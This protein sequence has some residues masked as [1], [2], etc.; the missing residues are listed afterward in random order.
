MLRAADPAPGTLLTGVNVIDKAGG[1]VNG[2]NGTGYFVQSGSL[3]ID[4]AT[5]Q[6]F[7]S[8]GGD[9]SGGGAGL[10]GAVFVN[11]GATV[12]LNN[13]NLVSNYASGG[14]GGVGSVGGSLNGLFQVGSSGSTG[15]A[16]ADADVGGAYVNGGNGLNGYNGYAGGNASSGLGGTG[17]RGGNGSDGA[18][19]TADTVKAALDVGFDA[20]KLGQDT[21]EFGI[22]TGIA[23]TMTA[24][25]TAAAAGVNV[26]GP[27]TTHLAPIF[28]ALAGEFTAKA[29]TS[30]A[31]AG[32]DVA[33]AAFDAAYLTAITVTNIAVGSAGNGGAGGAGGR[34]GQGAFGFGG[35]DGGV[36]GNGGDALFL[37]AGAGGP[38]GTGGDGGVGGFGAGGGLG[39]DGGGAGESGFGVSNADAT[40]TGGAG[41]V[42]GFGGGA[43]ASGDGIAALAAGGNGGSAFG[44]AI[45]V[46]AGGTLIIQG[47]ALFE[48]N[49][50]N[51]GAG[52]TASNT[53]AA[54]VSGIVVG[55]DLYM[56]KGSTV[57]LD[58]GEGHV[59]Q[60][61]GNPY[62]TSISDDSASSMIP[63]GGIS[64]IPSGQGA[65]LTVKSGLVIFNGSN[66]YSGQT[67]LEGGVLQALD[68]D[69]IYYDSNINFAGGVLQSNGD[70]T[71]AVG[72]A[73]SKV[74]WTGDGGFAAAG[75]DLS[76]RL[77]NGATLTWDSGSFVPT[78][79]KLIFGS[80]SADSSVT[81]FNNINLNGGNRTIV[82]K[83]NDLIP[84]NDTDEEVPANID[85]ATIRGVLSNGSLTVG[86][87][88]Y[89]GVLNLGAANTYAGGTTVNGGTLALVEIHNP[90][91]GHLISTGS[92]NA[93]GAVTVDAAGTFDI[94]QT[95]DQSIGALAGAGTVN[96]GANVLTL[97]QATD[98]T[99]SGAL[100]DGGIG[101]GEGAGVTKKGIGTLTL[102]G[103]N[104]YT[105][106]TQIDAGRITLTGT[107][108]SRTVNVASGATLDDVNGGLHDETA[109]TNAGT[110]NLSADD[111]VASF[112]SNAG[113]LNGAGKSLT[114][115]TYDLNTGTTINASL[116]AGEVT[117]NGTVALNGTSAAATFTIETGTTTLGSAER[118]LDT[119]DLTLSDGATLVLGGNEKIGTL[120]GA[121]SLNNNGGRL[122]VD[123]GS[124]SGVI[125]G[126]GGLTKVSSGK[127]T[128]TGASTYTGSTLI[129][130]GTVELSGSGSLVSDNVQIASGA[131]LDDLN[132][133]LSASAAVTNDGTLNIAAADDTITTL[134]NTG[135]VNGT[136][137]LTATTYNL[138]DSSV[139]NANLGT[140]TVNASGAVALNGTSNAETVNVQTGTTTLGSAERLRDDTD[141]TVSDGATLVLGG[142]EKIGTF[143][144]AGT[145]ALG[146]SQLTV[147]DG[148]YSGVVTGTGGIDKVSSGLLTL[149]GNST[150]TG[151]TNVDAGTLTLTG[152]LESLTVTVDA[153]TTINNVNGGLAE[154]ATLNND[155]TTVLG[156][157][158]TIT[159]FNS[160]DTLDGIGKTLTAETY[161]LNDGSVIN[162]NLGTGTVNANGEVALNGTSSAETV[163][164]QTGTTTL[165]SA[166]R[167]LD[168]TDLTISE[169]ATLILGGDEKIG[170]LDG[171]GVLQNAGGRL[172]VDDGDFSGVISGS[173]GLTKV[174][175]GTLTLSGEN[176][177]TG[178]TLITAGAVTL[179]GS[180]VSN[181]VTVDAGASLNDRESGLANDTVLTVN[182]TA[183]LTTSDTIDTLNGSG[184]VELFTK[185]KAFAYAKPSSTRLTV[186]QGDFSGV[187]SG[188]GGLTK[189]S[190]G[191]LVLSGENTYTGSTLI[192]AGALTLDGSLV[193]DV[194]TV[195]S[196]ASL[197][198]TASGLADDTTLTV[199][200]TATLTA[201][202]T[203]DTLNGSGSVVLDASRLTVSQGDFSG[204]VSGDG[205]LTKVTDGT[206]ALSGANTYTGSTQIDVG[207]VNLTG[208]LESATVTVAS[209]ATLNSTAGGLA[210]GSVLN[211]DGTVALASADDTVT[212]LNNTGT[213]NGTATLTAATYNLKGG[214]EINANLGAGTLNV[215]NGTTTLNGTS[216]AEIVNVF[217]GGTLT[218]GAAERLLDAAAV[219]VDGTL[220]LN[221]GDETIK[222]LDGS[223]AVN[224]NTFKLTVTNGGAFTGTLTA[225]T[226]VSDG[227]DLVLDG[228]TTT[229]DT[230][231]VSNG[232][233]LD[234]TNGGTVNTGGTTVG[235]GSSIDVTDGGTL[236]S[237][238]GITVQNGSNL[239][240]D[241][242]GTVT[243]TTITVQANGQLTLTT[244]YTLSYDTLTGAGLVETNGGT[245]TNDSGST[246]KGF[247]TFSDD[248]TNNGTFAPGNSPGVTVIA[249]NY[250]EAGTLETEFENT[251]PITG[252]DQVRV[253]GTVT[254]APTAT[255]IVQTYNGA[256]PARGDVFQIIS[257]LAGGAK[258]INGT[259]GSVLFDL[260]GLAGPAAPAASAAVVFDVATGRL[261]ATGLNAPGS[262]FADLG[263][264][265]N[266]RAAAAAIFAVAQN[267]VGPN[268]VDTSLV[269][270]PGFF[271]NQIID[272]TGN[273]QADLARYTPDYYGALADYA[274]TGD[275][276]L[277]RRVQ[278]RVSVTSDLTG[279]ESARAAAF[280][281]MINTNADTADNASVD[282][283][284]YFAGGDLLA[285]PGFKLGVAV[286][287]HEGDIS[288]PLGSGNADGIGG[289]LYARYALSNKLT[290]FGTLGYS[291]YDYDLRRATVNGTVTGSTN[292]NAFTGSVGVQHQGWTKGR[293][294]V[295]PRLTIA[296]S[297]SSVDGFTETGATDAL[298]NDGY[299]STLVTGEAGASAVWSAPVLGHAFNVELSL[300]LEQVLVDENDNLN[301]RVAS[302]PAI[303]YPV[304]FA[305]DASTRL[306]YGVNVGY[307]AYKLATV[308]AGYEGRTG[309]G[310][311]HYLN[312]GVRVGF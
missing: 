5:L 148:T 75:G 35:G 84:E 147:D 55:T 296:Y 114:A 194:V 17:G 10:G 202:D 124:F 183:T 112:V 41:G 154:G 141:L 301:V 49:G 19:I 170:T 295:A 58:A 223:G 270:G 246:V 290:A 186:N 292:A 277:A 127:L 101:G 99:F 302:T 237:T 188:N 43:G 129:D 171:A 157:D 111:T 272:A 87:A 116:G 222:T 31:A 42:A 218:L 204:I 306:T 227:G 248:F 312:L 287:K 59:I 122:T 13:V 253:G 230:T 220:N 132:G 304:K 303:A 184:E 191:T 60:F 67:K 309:D 125:S 238:G 261:I 288:A 275:R 149:S 146:A 308:Y 44:G 279:A 118:L 52:Q 106:T 1:T 233:S 190:D 265:S 68:G 37:S 88:G 70:F 123:D 16:G 109:L 66:L 258:V 76:V 48:G 259:F 193:S 293:L 74:Q 268:Q 156:A 307:N 300:G 36:G 241:D 89:E 215:T 232:G 98:T 33:K 46:R 150:Y 239:T 276:A 71:R 209:G 280:A 24:L 203:I 115:A 73:S 107:L 82:V 165:G 50:L 128:L 97:N 195:A 274:F 27:T 260:D 228:G 198:D 29:G 284:D 86:G 108:E 298:T 34:G 206:L 254:I 9:G 181:V 64:P 219:L 137:T 289:L 224:I 139:I 131:T 229:N 14:A 25:S 61:N 39:G 167:L 205:G 135:T 65:G 96:L 256:L 153:G 278:D 249:G 180:L 299:D 264:N 105:G 54:G 161:N 185:K 3:T 93:N 85:K 297:Q 187:I 310:S 144:G 53:N 208:S 7:N 40:G 285:V 92:L 189:V 269:S 8:T 90:V 102:S 255:L 196:G 134:T 164:I 126:T 266:Q 160:T 103:T 176:T 78:G 245:F 243:T 11:T 207:T 30:T 12:T 263:A 38:G 155:G 32:E 235:D 199:N 80:S 15:G 231:T 240:V 120:D 63:S 163:N 217:S 174:S 62:G 95:G 6:N 168:T 311:S 83:A 81:F 305:N 273:P 21:T 197:N 133:G 242:T 94:S 211:N 291:T 69:G 22:Y 251:T 130:A 72:T 158:D 271:A 169:E 166:E 2:G 138:N 119:T 56:M 216:A 104:S 159:T 178:S 79:N 257:D 182:G 113:T 210:S 214:S 234:I 26:G 4:N 267:L 262:T 20:Y 247:L 286:S 23:G 140:G 151:T 100:N 77:S 51:Q 18:S 283:T 281:G 201:D 282:R 192:N 28:A 212:T 173:G 145:T 172:T 226:L 236:N 179:D 221:G 91:N 225:S 294:S 136:A 110:I 57:I 175:S 250:T 200:G 244:G 121:G 152:S 162:A 252:H 143:D 45:F 213:I 117:A 47:D 142:N 177:Y